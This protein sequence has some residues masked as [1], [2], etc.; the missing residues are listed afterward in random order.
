MERSHIR[1]YVRV[2]LEDYDAIAT[3]YD[4]AISAGYE[5]IG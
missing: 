5:V 1:R 2:Q 4:A 3:M